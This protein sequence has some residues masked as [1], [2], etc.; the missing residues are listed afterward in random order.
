[1]GISLQ[2]RRSHLAQ[3]FAETGVA[4]QVSPQHKHIDEETDQSLYLGA[5]AIGA[6]G[7]HQ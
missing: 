3:Q 2:A 4:R 6:G 7:S 1:M 5:V